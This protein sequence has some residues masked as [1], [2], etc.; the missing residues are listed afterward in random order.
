MLGITLVLVAAGCVALGSLVISQSITVGSVHELARIEK[1]VL[2][3][4]AIG[5]ALNLLGSVFWMLGRQATKS[6]FFAWS[7]YLCSLVIIGAILASIVL[8]EDL[9]K[10]QYLIGVCLIVAGL[11][12]FGAR[13]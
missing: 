1:N 7:L 13:S 4:I 11:I 6:Y 10:I 9:L 12:A 8:G 2:A 5:V 3:Q